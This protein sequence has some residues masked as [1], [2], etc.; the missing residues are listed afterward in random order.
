MKGI[1]LAGGFGTRLYPATLAV[2]KQILPVYDK[3]MI[4]YPLSALM[5]AGIRDILIISNPETLPL[6]QKLFQ[7][8]S[9]LGL[10][11]SYCEQTY[12]RGLADAF[13]VGED[14]I[15]NDEVCLIL[16]DNIFYGHGLPDQLE[17][18]AQLKIGAKVFGYSVN[19][20]HRYG[21]A[22]VSKNHRVI[23]IEE[24]PENPKSNYAVTGVYFYDN[25]VVKIAKNLKP[26]A[27][28]EIEITAI[29]QAYL[30]K[31]QLS[32]E[33]LG[34]GTAWFDMGTHQSLLE[35][36]HFISTI[37]NR[38]GF[39]IACLEEIALRK[40]Y[41]GKDQFR[42]LA[43]GIKKSDYGIYLAKILEELS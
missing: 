18:S 6:F 27:R 8:G 26:S 43:E 23:S 40:G 1:I 5:L 32:I 13:I 2:S 41:I 28:G 36:S 12:P 38:Q 33:I 17:A 31:E 37:Q 4:Y 21:I 30:E 39:S 25:Q 42:L 7:D 34:R 29:N 10:K 9:Q 19:D 3:P 14:F 11:I 22:E 16:G 24:K 20:P 35:A 15:G